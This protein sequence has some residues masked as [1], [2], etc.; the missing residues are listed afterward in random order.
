M[1]FARLG[2]VVIDEQHRFGVMQRAALRQK[3]YSPHVLA[4]TAT[5]IPRTLALTIYGDLDISVINELPP[6]R[7][8]IKTYWLGPRE[9]EKAYTI[10]RSPGRCRAARPSSSA[11]WW[12]SPRCWRSSPPPRS[13]SAC[14]RRSSRTCGWACCTA[15]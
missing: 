8:T 4:M 6:G 13:T 5:P 1:E 2:L 10:I 14:T 3:G 7:Q 12:R 11:R 9:R 15:G